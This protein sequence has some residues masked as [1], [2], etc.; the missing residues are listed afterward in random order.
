MREDGRMDDIYRYRYGSLD[1]SKL[2]KMP[3]RSEQ[4]KQPGFQ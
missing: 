3:Q 2:N 1:A 4:V